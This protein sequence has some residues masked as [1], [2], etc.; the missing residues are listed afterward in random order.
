VQGNQL[1]YDKCPCSVDSFAFL[2][3]SNLAG[4]HFHNLK[5][6]IIDSCVAHNGPDNFSFTS[7]RVSMMRNSPG[8]TGWHLA[9]Q[10]VFY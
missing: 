8:W 1:V 7:H 9:M 6:F 4:S 3:N 2:T 5:L 10:F